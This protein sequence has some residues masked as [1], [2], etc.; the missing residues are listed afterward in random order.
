MPTSCEKTDGAMRFSPAPSFPRRDA[1]VG[2]DVVQGWVTKPVA[3]MPQVLVTGALV[4]RGP[5]RLT[6][7]R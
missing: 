3:V 6:S 2:D 4:E 1:P 5:G 7:A